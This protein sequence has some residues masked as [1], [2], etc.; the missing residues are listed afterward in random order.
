MQLSTEDLQLIEAATQHIQH[1]YEEGKH[2]VA[3]AL[4][5]RS[6][7]II[8]AVNMEGSFGCI[9]VCAEQVALGKAV[10]ENEK[11]IV[12][13]VT[14]KKPSVDSINQE[15]RV[16]SPCG[17]CREQLMDYAVQGDIIVR[18]GETVFKVPMKT[19]LPY[20]YVRQ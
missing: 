18:D 5:M 9:D 13:V 20:R 15:I 1:L 17:L 7:K 10:S 6:G 12:C 8:C 14:V 19:L 3:T 16:V 11:D 2:G 4:R